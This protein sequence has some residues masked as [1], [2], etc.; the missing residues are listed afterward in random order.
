MNLSRSKT[1]YEQLLYIINC[2]F[3][4]DLYIPIS[5]KDVPYLYIPA[6]QVYLD[7]RVNQFKK[8]SKFSSYALLPRKKP[9]LVHEIGKE[10]DLT[11][12]CSYSG[13]PTGCGHCN[14]TERG[15]GIEN[16]WLDSLNLYSESHTTKRPINLNFHLPLYV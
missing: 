7:I 11:N 14:I 5:R 8:S 6:H 4:I 15:N 3:K 9:Q 13:F 16:S 12:L 10:A 2:W 1:S